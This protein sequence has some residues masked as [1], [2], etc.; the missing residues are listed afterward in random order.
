M[1][2][3]FLMRWSKMPIFKAVLSS[4]YFYNS[5]FSVMEWVEDK[6]LCHK[7]FMQFGSIRDLL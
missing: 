4:N 2:T 7:K 1:K 3:K 6:L 5:H